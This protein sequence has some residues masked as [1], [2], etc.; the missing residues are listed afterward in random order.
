MA[1][2]LQF[3][4]EARRSLLSGVEQLA[5][6][7]KVTLGPKGRNVVL[8]K[9]FGKTNITK[10]GVSVAKE[11]ELE[12]PYENT[13]AQMVKE[14]ASKTVNIA[15]DG[16]TTATVLAEAIYKEGLKN[17]TAGANPMELKRG[18]DKAIELI[19]KELSDISETVETKEQIEQ[20]ATI[21]AN[22]D[23]AIGEIIAD[24]MDKVGKDGVITTEE[25][26]SVETILDVVE[27][28]QFDRGYLS[29]HMAN[30]EEGDECVLEDVCILVCDQRISNLEEMLPLLQKLST[31]QK[32]FLIIA[33]DVD[34]EALSTLIINKMNGT[35]K[36]AVVKAP[37]FGA[38]KAEMLKDI[39]TVAGATLISK[40]L[41]MSLSSATFER[42]GVAKKIVV[43]KDKTTIVE[44]GGSKAEIEGRISVIKDQIDKTDSEYEKAK[45]KDRLAKLS[46]GVAVIKIGATT[47]T[48]LKEKQDRFDDALCATRSAVEEGVVAGGGVA[49]LRASSVLKDIDLQGDELV[50]AN[51]VNK[52]VSAPLKQISANGGYEG[53]VVV[54]K[55]LGLTGSN[56]FN[57]ANGEYV[58]MIEEGI[59]D[60]TKVT[61]TA[62]QNAGSISGLLLTTECI[63]A[64]EKSDEV[65]QIPQYI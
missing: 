53:S 8:V 64:E 24:A 29:H 5:K 26:P 11:M 39:C 3:G 37:S 13:G 47:E 35:L 31:D 42:C 12:C 38:N 57:C 19:V 9:K 36:T 48:E 49:L 10:D 43:T 40:S 41:G 58:D 17:V 56:G 61:R 51:I 34:G 7:V 4:D 22:G 2:K 55:V 44:G 54:E 52:A 16:T 30:N 63:V 65:A 18:V 14:V 23:K 62:L 6:A 32:S 33:E 46:G 15:G 45:L 20:I 50:G 28:L 59:I 1:K 21:S 27:G 60:P 25:A